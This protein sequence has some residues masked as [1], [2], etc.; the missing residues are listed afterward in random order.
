[1]KRVVL[2]SLMLAAFLNAPVVHAK[3]EESMQKLAR[4]AAKMEK[5]GFPQVVLTQQEEDE[6]ISHVVQKAKEKGITL[7]K[8]Q[9]AIVSGQIAGMASVALQMAEAFS[10]AG[11]KSVQQST[12]MEKPFTYPSGIDQY[13]VAGLLKNFEGNE[14][15]TVKAVEGKPICVVGPME[16]ITTETYYPNADYKNSQGK[17]PSIKMGL[18]HGYLLNDTA[19]LSKLTPSQTV[20]LMCKNVKKGNLHVQAECQVVAAGPIEKGSIQPVYLNADIH[21]LLTSPKPQ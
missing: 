12:P 19:D 1:M 18:F 3:P 9:A 13:S 21:K 14:F 17:F 2:C 16:S 4:S 7:S 15:A 10:G 8:Q 11:N 20:V 6:L 5:D